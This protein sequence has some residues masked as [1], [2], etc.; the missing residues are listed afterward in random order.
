MPIISFVQII[1]LLLVLVG[2]GG[3]VLFIMVLLKLNR[4]LDIWLRNNRKS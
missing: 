1:N 3:L 4:A 2:A